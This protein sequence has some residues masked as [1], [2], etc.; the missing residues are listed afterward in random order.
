MWGKAGVAAWRS[1]ESSDGRVHIERREC[2]VGEDRH[3]RRA[4]RPAEEHKKA[5]EGP[6]RVETKKC[7]CGGGASGQG[8]VI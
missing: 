8:C 5:R 4:I 7:K 6:E 1:G 3:S 2:L